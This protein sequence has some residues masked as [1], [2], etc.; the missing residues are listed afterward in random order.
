MFKTY[1]YSNSLIKL[2]VVEDKTA[3]DLTPEM[4]QAVKEDS[5]MTHPLVEEAKKDYIAKIKGL[6]PSQ[7][8]EVIDQLWS[9]YL[10][11]LKKLPRTTNTEFPDYQTWLQTNEANI[12]NWYNEHFITP[13][14]Q[15]PFGK[16][17][18]ESGL[19]VKTYVEEH[20]APGIYQRELTLDKFERLG[21]NPQVET[22]NPL[23]KFNALMD[24]YSRG[25]AEHFTQQLDE[26][27]PSG[28]KTITFVTGHPGA[29]KSTILELDNADKDDPL[30]K[31]RFGTLIDP[32]EFQPYLPGFSGG[33]RS[34]DVLIYAKQLIAKKL[35]NEAMNRGIDIAIPLVGGQA[36][37][38]AK[39]IADALLQGYNV[40]VIHKELSQDE[41]QQRS[42]SRAEAGGRLIA[43]NTGTTNPAATYQDLQ[44]GPEITNKITSILKDRI[45]EEKKQ[46][47][48]KTRL[49]TDEEIEALLRR[50]HFFNSDKIATSS[51][52]FARKAIRVAKNLE[53]IREFKAVDTIINLL[54][55][56]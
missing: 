38:L 49:L 19:D 50:V 29:G 28:G 22:N 34:G 9:E 20:I 52:T 21:I 25:V 56:L 24:N 2:A 41:S 10:Q 15:N 6:T 13:K 31:T 27:E 48:I 55:K 7:D 54:M 40:N 3:M 44:E 45:K 12:V 43:P 1:N 35:Q 4:I 5:S 17:L 30:R 8:K 36:N 42:T 26:I 46:G 14:N 53:S 51:A 37:I 23:I 47:E 16:S 32:D 39:D 18:T 11:A 33:A